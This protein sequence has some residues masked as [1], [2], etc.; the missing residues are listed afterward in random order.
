M[1]L[2]RDVTVR[3]HSPLEEYLDH[4]RREFIAA[5]GLDTGQ[6]DYERLSQDILRLASRL[7][8]RVVS[9][10]GSSVCYLVVGRVQSGKTGHQLGML[11]WAAEHCD[12]AI[13]FTGMTEA[14]NGQ[15]SARIGRDLRSLPS[16][17]VNV[18]KVPTR[19]AIESNSPIYQQVSARVAA[20]RAH[21]TGVRPWPEPLPVLT[22][23]KTVPRVSALTWMFDALRREHGDELIVLIIDDEADQASPNAATARD[24]E[25]ATYSELRDLRNSISSHAW[26]SYT[27][28]PQAI[29]LTETQGALR[30]DFC[31][32]T[33]PGSDYF[34]VNDLEGRDNVGCRV[35]VTDFDQA[36]IGPARYPTSLKRAL[37]DFVCSAWARTYSPADF[38]SGVSRPINTDQQMRSVQM[39]VHTDS[40][41]ASHQA[42][43]EALVSLQQDL[44]GD[45]EQALDGG[46][47]P[48]ELESAWAAMHQRVLSSRHPTFPTHMTEETLYQLGRLLSQAFLRV[49]NSRS[50]SPGFEDGPLPTSSS[51]WER[52]PLWIIIGGDILGR[53][54]TLPQLT[55]MYFT[56]EPGSPNEDTV[57]Q[58][59]RF[60]GYR[61]AYRRMLRIY[62][63]PAVL[64][65]FL[66]IAVAERSYLSRVQVWDDQDRNIREI[67][68]QLWYVARPGGTIRPTR[69]SVRDRTLR[70]ND[71]GRQ[72][73]SA[74]QIM[75]PSRFQRNCATLLNWIRPSGSIDLGP[76]WQTLDCGTEDLSQLLSELIFAGADS[77]QREVG[78]ELLNPS[79]GELGL[80]DMA[81]SIMVRN[82]TVLQATA[83]GTVPDFA[84]VDVHRRL[85][86]NLEPAYAAQSWRRG[87]GTLTNFREV[88][89][90]DTAALAVQH[91]GDSQRRAVAR[92]NH[93]AVSLLLEPVIGRISNMDTAMG[94]AVSMLAPNGYQI[95]TIG[96]DIAN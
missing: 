70:D 75:S 78:I 44:L 36:R 88:V 51:D 43:Y 30:P 26:L 77:R 57:A 5:G 27:A 18:I 65:S 17:P 74:R 67:R 56:R 31:L 8:V 38:Y 12:L 92:M 19:A 81:A 35:P 95:R 87:F 54:L 20:R 14:L 28:T 96:V 2:F 32:L 80:S 68:P 41:V 33:R 76:S 48:V 79:L 60:A 64:D 29:F 69:L 16:A 47:P 40:R 34:G 10:P 73:F 11:A 39:L 15:T 71:I 9:E 46:A 6:A 62:T 90:Y 3:E 58:Q 7:E 13:F 94:L 89:W 84:D 25:A 1:N 91:M 66:D 61:Q 42:D 63:P 83:Q 45:I 85:D 53:G 22:S 72:V 37:C 93:D 52:H 24:E 21:M 4:K 49:V 50:Q 82:I 55:C 23:M 86:E 59:M